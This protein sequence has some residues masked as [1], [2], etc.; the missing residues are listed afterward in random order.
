M[1]GSARICFVGDSLTA[2]YRDGAFTGWPGRLCRALAS[3]GLDITCYNLGIRG[4]SSR[5]ILARWAAETVRRMPAEYPR[6]AVFSF[7]VN[8]TR[9]VEGTR[10]VEEDETI[11]NARSILSGAETLFPV[12]FVGPAAV[13][14][15]EQNARIDSLNRRLGPL[16]AGLGVPCLDLFGALSSDS[17]WMRAIASDGFHPS[18][19]GYDMIAGIV[20]RWEGWHEFVRGLTR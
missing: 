7:G 15:A 12:L 18:D 14:D 11:R 2:G 10:R 20:E 16:C 13:G 6:G 17:R 1:S 19:E 5:D 9:I 8:D 4:D 3:K